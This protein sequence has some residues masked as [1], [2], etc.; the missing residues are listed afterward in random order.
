MNFGNP[1]RRFGGKRGDAP[2]PNA[3][4]QQE[5]TQL[6]LYNPSFLQRLPHPSHP[7]HSD[8][9]YLQNLERIL[10]RVRRRERIILVVHDDG[11]LEVV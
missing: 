11:S 6:Q 10:H 2:Q 4:R 7:P 3:S 9:L 1:L 8:P 5:S